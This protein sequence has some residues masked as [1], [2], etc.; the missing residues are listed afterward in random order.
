M[1]LLAGG[2]PALAESSEVRSGLSAPAQAYADY[3]AGRIARGA[4]D[5]DNAAKRLTGALRAD[6]ANTA[7]ARQAFLIQLG[8]GRYADALDLAAKLKTSGADSFLA[9]ALQVSDLLSRNKLPEARARLAEV[10]ADG[11]GQFV[12]PLLAA[13]VEVAAGQHDAA[14]AKLSVLEQTPGFVPLHRLQAALIED[15][16]GNGAVAGE[17]YAKALEGGTPLRLMQLAGNFHER[18]GRVEAARALYL[19][20]K[21]ENPDS[22][23]A[24]EALARL[25][26]DGPAPRRLVAD[27]KDGLAEALFELASAMHQESAQEMALMFGR[28]SQFLRSDQA[29]ARIMTGDVLQARS[30][31][32]DALVEYKAAVD[33]GGSAVAW[34][35]RLRQADMLRRLDRVDEAARLLEAMATERPAR[36]DALAR[37]GDV[38]R[39]QERYGEAA[40][41]YT[42]ALT[43]LGESPKLTAGLLYVRGMSLDA[44]GRW[45]E[46]EA[47]LKRSLELNPDNASVLNY[48]GYSWADRGVNLMQARALL[49]KAV[50][51][52]P[53]DGYIIDSLGWVKLKQ[54]DIAGAVELLER[55]VELHPLDPAMNDHLGDA[56]WAAGRKQEARFQ[57]T[58]AAQQSADKDLKQAAEDKLKNG[59]PLPKTAETVVPKGE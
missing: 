22:L 48:L 26:K 37:L 34:M 17:L 53:D 49:E 2:A 28:L 32:A 35:A 47:D 6:P 12:V 19:S 1:A 14:L 25:D 42:R 57:W 39:S 41:A 8:E 52:K 38:L 36:S 5:W 54:G 33:S 18:A 51:L 46:G 20:V 10:P 44:A 15:L 9:G 13:W 56:Y 31:H 23:A 58:R 21:A 30:R 40:D 11:L 55:A 7:L 24:D 3:L 43:R 50:G 29:L 16:R 45:A 4:G 59:L 27:A